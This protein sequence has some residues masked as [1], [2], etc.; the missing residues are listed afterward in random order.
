MCCFNKPR[1]L[2]IA[3]FLDFL[4]YNAHFYAVCRDGLGPRY[5]SISRR[6]VPLHLTKNELVKSNIKSLF[7]GEILYGILN[8]ID[9]LK[10]CP[11]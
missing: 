3:F 6:T 1:H 2:D 7:Q 11:E 4:F 5:E 8:I 10:I 9:T